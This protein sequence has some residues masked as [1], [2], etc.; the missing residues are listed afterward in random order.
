MPHHSFPHT[1]VQKTHRS[2]LRDLAQSLSE[3]PDTLS[4]LCPESRTTCPAEE[5]IRT[6]R[7]R[8]AAQT[9][10]NA[11]FVWMHVCPECGESFPQAGFC[12]RDGSATESTED[13]SFL[14]QTVGAYR[15]AR[16]IGVGGMGRVYKGVNP[17][18]GSR[19]AIKVLSNDCSQNKELVDRFFSEAK[20][21]NVIR[22]ESIVN[23]LNLDRLPDGR[24]YIVME[25]LDGMPLSKVIALRRQL[26]LGSF[27]RVIGETLS[28]LGAAHDKGVIH[29]DLKPDNIYVT[30]HGRAKVLDFG[31]AK[32]TGDVAGVS[33]H[34]RDGSLMG[35]PHYMAPEQAQARPVDPRT[36]VY[37]IGV[38]LFEGTTGQPPFAAEALYDLLR[39][40]VE[41][42]PPSPR[43]LRPDM[44]P[45]YEAVILRALAKDPAHR[46]QSAKAL[47]RELVAATRS[48]PETAWEPIGEQESRLSVGMSAIPTPMGPPTPSAQVHRAPSE[49]AF[50]P[51]S[52]AA[53]SAPP[54]RR[55]PPGHSYQPTPSGVGQVYQTAPPQKKIAPFVLVGVGLAALA[56]VGIFFASSGGDDKKSETGDAPIATA[57]PANPASPPNDP[58]NDP[59]NGKKPVTVEP[60]QGMVIVPGQGN[61]ADPK[62]Y[63]F[64]VPNTIGTADWPMDNK[65]FGRR[66]T[67]DVS[68]LDIDGYFKKAEELAK[69][70]FPDAKLARIDAQ[71]V[72]PDG[73]SNL[74]LD[75]GFFVIYKFI[76]P[77]RSIRPDD[78]P[79][80]VQ[81]KPTC[82]Y[83]VMF[84]HN[85]TMYNKL[86]GWE[87]EPAPIRLPRCS[88]K[89][90]WRKAIA[91]G[92]PSKNAVAQVGYWADDKGNP[93]WYFAI[94]NRHSQF[95]PDD[96]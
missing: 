41:A 12:S 88:V 38:I 15:I 67:P 8:S 24:P 3:F 43:S 80:G 86:E 68:A 34:T 96:C 58:L 87:C 60:G 49:P 62:N 22:H 20:A 95:F 11:I 33:A 55:P 93:R 57:D 72:S 76:S 51:R 2:Q 52:A 94:G 37:S 73:T 31:I 78:L 56:G 1:Q 54:P 6:N 64:N 21:V 28:A 29:R 85:M 77:S 83:N 61:I 89:Q 71:G 44:S 65:H 70:A 63:L 45:E 25:F 42:P 66:P 7:V 16:L 47:Y 27:A 13:D 17:A 84:M 92:A 39:M 82:L 48:L 26:P 14:G 74:T 18:I 46:Q 23:V 9:S 32:L 50:G 30:P 91:K 36:D 40:H 35:T 10:G 53:P 75:T 81:H 69:K 19:V 59:L 90:V 79:M 5:P 4:E